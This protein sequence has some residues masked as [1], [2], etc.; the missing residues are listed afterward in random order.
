[1]Q[2]ED[3]VDNYLEGYPLPS[4][5][6]GLNRELDYHA[7]VVE[8]YARHVRQ[9]SPIRDTQPGDATPAA[10]P[11]GTGRSDHRLLLDFSQLDVELLSRQRSAQYRAAVGAAAA[12]GD[13]RVVLAGEG[14]WRSGSQSGGRVQR[15]DQIE[16]VGI[17]DAVQ[18]NLRSGSYTRGRFS[19]KREKGVPAFHRMYAQCMRDDCSPK[20]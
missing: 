20:P 7:Y 1:M 17:C 12:A 8:P 13:L 19:V 10:L 14:P 6:P 2:L 11:G 15:S 18:K 4:A 9:F 5:H 16:D 3:H